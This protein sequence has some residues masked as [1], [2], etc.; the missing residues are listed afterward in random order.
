MLVHATV[1]NSSSR[2]Y[3]SEKVLPASYI[4]I[5]NKSSVVNMLPFRYLGCVLGVGAEGV[6]GIFY[7]LLAVPKFYSIVSS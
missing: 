4:L 3:F 2:G 5:L 1:G 6:V 7:L